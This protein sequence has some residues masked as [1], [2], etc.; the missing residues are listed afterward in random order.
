MLIKKAKYKKVKV[1]KRQEISPEVHGCDNCKVVLKSWPNE[2]NRLDMTVWPTK[3]TGHDTQHYHFCSWDCVLKYI[4]KI[5]S[6]YFASMPHLMFDSEG[7]G[8]VTELLN[9]I[10]LLKKKPT[11]P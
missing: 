9:A 11:K 2:D 10:N 4:P 8:S 6:T 1:W 3:D 7:K 5:K